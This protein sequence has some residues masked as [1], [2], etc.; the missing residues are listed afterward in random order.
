MNSHRKDRVAGCA[1]WVWRGSGGEPGMCWGPRKEERAP[2]RG[3]KQCGGSEPGWSSQAH[4]GLTWLGDPG[5][6]V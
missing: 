5:Q 2:G 3:A 1:E 4:L 6:V